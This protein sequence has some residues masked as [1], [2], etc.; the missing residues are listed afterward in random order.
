[1]AFTV[2]GEDF[3]TPDGTC[4]RDYVHVWDIAL[5]HV[6]AAGFFDNYSPDA[7]LRT[8]ISLTLNLGTNTGVSN[9]E[10]VDYVEQKYGL[11]LVNFG[12]KRPGDPARLIADAG[13][14]RKILGWEPVNSEIKQ[15]IDDAYKWYM[16]C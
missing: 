11:L 9:K 16:K 1:M 3:D 7:S 10:I 2:N 12:P 6:R 5:A 13:N 8:N 4:I 14:A 15:I